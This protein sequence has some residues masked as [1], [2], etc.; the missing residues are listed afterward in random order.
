MHP[1]DLVPHER[2]PLL[3]RYAE[4]L[5]ALNRGVN[6]VARQS[7][8][9]IPEDH[10][11]HCVTLAQRGFPAGARVVDWG[12]GGGLP[13]IPLA[14]CFPTVEFVAVD[15][16][17]KKTEAVRIMAR[18]LGLANVVAWNGRAEDWRETVYATVSRATAVLETL[19]TWSEPWVRGP[20]ESVNV[21]ETWP[22]G[23]VCLK[24]G[25]LGEEIAALQRRYPDVQVGATELGNRFGRPDWATKYILTVTSNQTFR[26]EA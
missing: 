18:R 24:G 5:A 16:I 10:V 2:R 17:A 9:R 23:L 20:A 15:S 13:A 21:A 11:A 26:T 22:P 12:S 14:I 25:E 7:A 1:F 3:D 19:W 8:S 4:E 6:L